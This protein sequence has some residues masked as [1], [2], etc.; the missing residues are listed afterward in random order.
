[1][2]S[3]PE[4]KLNLSSEN[5]RKFNDWGKEQDAK[6]LVLNPLGTA[7]ALDKYTSRYTYMFT[8]T[9]LGN[10]IEVRNNITNEKIDLTDFGSW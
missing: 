5:K 4:F 1:M 10:V 2:S 3:Q 7:G 8:P 6:I 9:S